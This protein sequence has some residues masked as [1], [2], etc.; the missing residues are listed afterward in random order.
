MKY[1]L[2][3][4]VTLNCNYNC[5]FCYLKRKNENMNFLDVQRIIN[6]YN[7]QINSLTISGGEPLIHPEIIG[8]VDFLEQFDFPINLTSN[9]SEFRKIYNRQIGLRINYWI[10]IDRISTDLEQMITQAAY[11]GYRIFASVPLYDNYLGVLHSLIKMAYFFSGI[12]LLIPTPS[13]GKKYV[14]LNPE[15][16]FKRLENTFN[17]IKPHFAKIYY[18]PG[19]REKVISKSKRRCQSGNAIVINPDLLSYPCC[20][21][22]QKLKGEKNIQ[23]VSMNDSD[24][25]YLSIYDEYLK[26]SP[27]E[28][29]CPI[30]VK[31]LGEKPEGYL[32]HLH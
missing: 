23:P 14:P 10:G 32:T 19:F 28:A 9:F 26:D 30:F 25:Y 1:D 3:L 11:R 4:N 21:V 18:E 13:Y 31:T 16:W 27:Y 22:V 2:Q 29:L 17:I 15:E 12:L 6:H 7:K 20:L 24:C 8:I 5:S